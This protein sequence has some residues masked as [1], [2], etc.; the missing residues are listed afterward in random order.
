MKIVKQLRAIIIILFVWQLFSLIIHKSLVPSPISVLS[1]T[2]NIFLTK[3]TIHLFYSLLRILLGIIGGIIIGW[4]LGI[5]LGYF[6]KLDQVFS[7]IIYFLY[8]IPKIAFL[9]IL[10]L[11]LG[12]GE[13][14]KIIMIII[15]IL[16]QII[17]NIRDHVKNIEPSVFYP[18]ITLG[19][20][21]FQIIKY[22]V[23][24]SSLPKLFS[25]IRIALGTSI[26]VLFFS[27]TF[28]TTYGLGYFIM[29][30]MLRINY[31]EMYSGILMLSLLG[32]TLFSIIDLINDRI[33]NW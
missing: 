18:L 7:P 16:F 27:E 9:P 1:H 14:T 22:L 15:I 31:V 5:I 6:N 32:L 10:M 33:I 3:L 26:A 20:N 28:G 2:L 19:S 25:S 13:I 8:P 24:P 29:D 30:S 21:D 4:P 12:L 17:V 11:L 23:L